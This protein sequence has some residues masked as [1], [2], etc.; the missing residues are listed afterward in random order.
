M[1]DYLTRVDGI[2]HFAVVAFTESL[3][4]KVEEGVGVARFVRLAS[5]P[6]VAEAAVTVID[7]FQGRGL[8]RLLLV[9]LVEAARERGVK[10][11]HSEVL[12]SNDRMRKLLAAV[13]VKG[14]T[15]DGST[16]MFDVAIDEPA[17]LSL[18]RRIMSAVATSMADR[19]HRIYP[20]LRPSSRRS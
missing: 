1:L 14:Q 17:E 10:K 5:E 18:A 2:D 7:D 8:G 9:T 15:G 3:D 12:A 19:I 20:G 16:L 13:G 6:E 11:F 4:M